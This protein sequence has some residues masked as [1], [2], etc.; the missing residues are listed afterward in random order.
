MHKR[1]MVS[2]ADRYGRQLLQG[3]EPQKQQSKLA[4]IVNMDLFARAP[5]SE[6]ARLWSERYKAKPFHVAMSI[7]RGHF[8]N[9]LSRTNHHPMLIVPFMRH[10]AIDNYVVQFSSQTKGYCQAGF[11]SLNDY[12]AQGAAARPAMTL[13]LYSDLV[14]ATPSIGLVSGRFDPDLGI[15]DRDQAMALI[16]STSEAYVRL[17]EWLERFTATPSTF[18]Y[19]AY[20]AA[21]Q[22]MLSQLTAESSKRTL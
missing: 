18:D 8:V 10:Q 4:D 7:E 9:W 1:G 19:Q 11:A 12:R 5:P 3:I 2:F 16:V 20:L 6:A 22:S 13:N 15:N 14:D 17:T 21:F